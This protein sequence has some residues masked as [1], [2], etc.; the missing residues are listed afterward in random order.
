MGLHGVAESNIRV[1]IIAIAPDRSLIQPV[2]FTVMVD[3]PV[4]GKVL[5]P[6]IVLIVLKYEVKGFEFI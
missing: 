4:F 6:E 1:R 2:Y 3:V 5:I